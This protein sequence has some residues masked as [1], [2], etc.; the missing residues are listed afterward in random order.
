MDDLLVI[1]H[2]IK[3]DLQ[4]ITKSLANI[5]KNS[6]QI[7]ADEWLRQEEILKIMSISTRTFSRLTTSGKLPFTKLKGLIYVKKSDVDFLLNENHK[8]VRST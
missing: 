4:E 7:L 8:E 6:P 5:T 3:S 2:E 1:C